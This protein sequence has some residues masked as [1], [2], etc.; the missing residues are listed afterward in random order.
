MGGSRND[1]ND[2]VSLN[3]LSPKE[4][5]WTVHPLHDVSPTD[6]SLTH[7][8]R[9]ASSKRDTSSE[10]FCS[11]TRQSGTNGHWT[12][13]QCTNTEKIYFVVTAELAG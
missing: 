10:N 3:D 4:S 13:T 7:R 5:S 6:E 12:E 8:P 11:G 1:A 2:D 9:D